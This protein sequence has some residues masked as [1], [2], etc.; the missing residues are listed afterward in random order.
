MQI[1]PHCRRS[2]IRHNTVFTWDE[3]SSSRRL[4]FIIHLDTKDHLNQWDKQRSDEKLRC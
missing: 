4:R 3:K 1:K 2:G